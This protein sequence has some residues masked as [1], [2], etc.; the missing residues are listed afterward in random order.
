MNLFS[1]GSCVML[2]LLLSSLLPLR[3]QTAPAPPLPAA[4]LTEGAERK[5]AD[6]S[7][8][9][10]HDKEARKLRPEPILMAGDPRFQ[11]MLLL[12]TTA[13]DQLEAKMKNWPALAEMSDE[14]KKQVKEEMEGFRNRIFKVAIKNAEESGMSLTEEQKPAYVKSYWQRRSKVETEIRKEVQER[15]KI[16]MERE[17][18]E[19]KKEF[20][21]ALVP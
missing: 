19:L 8:R 14:R 7:F 17:N 12:A 16:A 6:K 1:Y 20:S 4:K 18:G 5:K 21:K 15:L 9:N 2:S 13:P 3:S 10:F 11:N